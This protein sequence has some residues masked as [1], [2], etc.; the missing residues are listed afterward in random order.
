MTEAEDAAGGVSTKPATK[1][2]AKTAV[3]KAPVKSA[4]RRSREL[5]LQGLYQWLLSGDNPDSIVAHLAEQDGFGKSDRAHFDALLHGGIEQAAAL[6][7]VLARH[8]DRKTTQLSP[9]EHAALMIGCY[10]LMHCLDV[11]YRVVINESVELTKSF[12]GTDGHKYVN[13]VLDRCA[14]ELRPNEAR[15]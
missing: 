11:P 2:A 3:K 14:A 9:V 8:V 13:G 6:D 1:P 4:R 15:R 10:E 5:A 12:G 7:A